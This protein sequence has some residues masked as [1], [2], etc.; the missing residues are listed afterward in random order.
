M[1]GRARSGERVGDARTGRGSRARRRLCVMRAV[2]GEREADIGR[3]RQRAG[4]ARRRGVR[5]AQQRWMGV[6]SDGL[7]GEVGSS[8]A[9]ATGPGREGAGSMDGRPG[10]G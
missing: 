1:L 7:Q 4:W 10:P 5:G 6:V 2:V 3:R 8:M 9:G